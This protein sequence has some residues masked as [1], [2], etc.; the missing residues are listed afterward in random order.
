[1]LKK[2]KYKNNTNFYTIVLRLMNYIL[3]F[4]QSDLLLLTRVPQIYKRK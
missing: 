3:F 1:L 2:H 4:K